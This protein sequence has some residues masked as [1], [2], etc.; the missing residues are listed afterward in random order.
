MM[1]T[2]RTAAL[3]GLLALAGLAATADRADAQ[4]Y[5]SN[6]PATT[7]YYNTVPYGGY[8]TYYAPGTSYSYATPYSNWNTSGYT[9]SSYYSTPYTA[10]STPYMGYNTMPYTAWNG[11]SNWGYSPYMGGYSP[12][13]GGYNAYYSN[14]VID[15]VNT[16]QAVRGVFRR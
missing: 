10:Y 16:Y 12:Y 11:A 15:A 2:I 14:P 7:Y 3:T 8:Q 13:N 1:R 9:Y 5:Y 6:Y 4:V